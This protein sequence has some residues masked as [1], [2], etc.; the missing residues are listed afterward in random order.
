M[1]CAATNYIM[2]HRW[3]IG[4]V[5]ISLLAVAPCH[6]EPARFWLS[7]SGTSS[8]G[9][10]APTLEVPA[11]GSRQLYIWG[12][13]ATDHKVINLSL[14]LVAAQPGVD[15][16]VPITLFNSITAGAQRFE[17]IADSSAVPPVQSTKSRAQVM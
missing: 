12:R 3:I 5:V 9:P 6:G 13:P 15:L 11:T 2:T 1:L 17:E 8:P 10:E 4:S 14:D 7:G 16:D